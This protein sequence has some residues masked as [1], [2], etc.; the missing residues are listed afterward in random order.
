MVSADLSDLVEVEERKDVP[1]LGSERQQ[2]DQDEEH[3]EELKH[4]EDHLE[5]PV[6]V[7][8]TGGH[9]VRVGVHEVHGHVDKGGD[10]G[11]HDLAPESRVEPIGTRRLQAAPELYDR[12]QHRSEEKE[13][14]ADVH[15]CVEDR[16]ALRHADVAVLVRASGVMLRDGEE[17]GDLSEYVET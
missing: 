4:E 12:L 2:D 14:E 11:T 7:D 17:L 3:R 13:F 15:A 6:A 10:R 9:L 5:E 1:L 16:G 8:V